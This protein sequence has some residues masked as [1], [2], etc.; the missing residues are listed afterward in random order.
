MYSAY[1][2]I[3]QPESP[4]E[5]VGSLLLPMTG[6]K[7]V[8]DDPVRIGEV[9]GSNPSTQTNMTLVRGQGVVGCISERHSEGAGSI[10]AVCSN[11]R[12]GN[13][14]SAPYHQ[15]QSSQHFK[16]RQKRQ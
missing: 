12:G 5:P 4:S 3:P 11:V 1:H 16:R 14:G 15:R 8:V 9:G 10:P 7:S 6:C 2:M 13:W